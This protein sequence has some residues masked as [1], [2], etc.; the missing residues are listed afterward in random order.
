[1]SAVSLVAR[2]PLFRTGYLYIAPGVRAIFL[3][4]GIDVALM[5]MKL[6]GRHVRAD[7]GCVL[8]EI[9]EQNAKTIATASLDSILSCYWVDKVGPVWVIT[10]SGHRM[11][12]ILLPEEFSDGR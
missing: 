2:A 10:K 4:H 7:H 5:A 12:T 8:E 3:R 1:M 9:A 11:T 6:F